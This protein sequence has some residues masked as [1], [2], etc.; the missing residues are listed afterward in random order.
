MVAAILL[1]V[2]VAAVQGLVATIPRIVMVA[3]WES[4]VATHSTAASRIAVVEASHPPVVV[5]VVVVASRLVVTR[6]WFA[7]ARF[8]NS[9]KSAR[10]Q[11]VLL[12]NWCIVA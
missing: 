11:V 9:H 2:M 8:R 4:A 10:S 5:A 12:R 6:D 1:P 7:V 3:V